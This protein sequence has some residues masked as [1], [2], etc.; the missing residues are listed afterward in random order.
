MADRRITLNKN[1]F[2]RSETFTM[3]S[4]RSGVQ[5]IPPKVFSSLMATICA[6]LY[7]IRFPL[8][9][10]MYIS[11]LMMVHRVLLLR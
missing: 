11:H 6:S 1:L 5:D 7:A 2:A 4:S 3:W 8:H 9:Q 10:L